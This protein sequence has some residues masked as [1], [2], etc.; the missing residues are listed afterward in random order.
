MKKKAVLTKQILMTAIVTGLCCGGGTAVL[1]ADTVEDF[2]LDSVVVTATR[3]EKADVD[4]PASTTILTNKDLKNTGAENMQ[5]ALQKVSGLAYTTYGPNGN[6]Y[7]TMTN[8][9]IIRGVSNGTLILINGTSMI[10]PGK[11]CV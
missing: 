11:P 2:T 3:S 9:I 6:P 8:P 7:S 4:V 10:F 5:M 1:A